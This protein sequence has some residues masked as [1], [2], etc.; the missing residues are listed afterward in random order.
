[1]IYIAIELLVKMPFQI[2][3]FINKHFS[4]N[5]TDDSYVMNHILLLKHSRYMLQV[6]FIDRTMVQCYT[7]C[8]NIENILVSAKPWSSGRGLEMNLD[9]VVYIFL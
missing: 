7:G 5:F 6:H 4:A 9:H 1:M 2:F 3:C 8:P